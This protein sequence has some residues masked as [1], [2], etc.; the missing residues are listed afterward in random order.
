MVSTVA[1]IHIANEFPCKLAC[2]ICNFVRHFSNVKAMLLQKYIM[3]CHV[4]SLMFTYHLKL[5]ISR[6]K[7]DNGILQ[8]KLILILR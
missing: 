7:Q 6:K 8:K 2:G 1:M 4:V 3:H 5:N